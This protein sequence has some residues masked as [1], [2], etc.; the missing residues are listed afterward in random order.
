MLWIL[1]ILDNGYSK[2]SSMYN[3]FDMA[4][5]NFQGVFDWML[6]W[7]AQ[8][9]KMTRVARQN[10]TDQFKIEEAPSRT[11][12]HQLSIKLTEIAQ[13]LLRLLCTI[14]WLTGEG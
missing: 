6:K 14:Q 2:N 1:K 12:A 10:R 3:R 5:L 7:K 11:E 8:L 9:I 13:Y 4:Q